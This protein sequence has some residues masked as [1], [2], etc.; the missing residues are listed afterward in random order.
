MAMLTMTQI[1]VTYT[2][3]THQMLMSSVNITVVIIIVHLSLTPSTF[4][5]SHS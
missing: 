1:N 2:S 5:C 4:P 3:C